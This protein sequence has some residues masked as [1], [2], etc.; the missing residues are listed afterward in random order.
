MPTFNNYLTTVSGSEKASVLSGLRALLGLPNYA[1]RYMSAATRVHPPINLNT[2]TSANN[3]RATRI[4][5]NTPDYPTYNTRLVY[6]NWYNDS[7]TTPSVETDTDGVLTL[8]AVGYEVGGVVTPVTFGGATTVDIPIGG[9]V[10][11]DPINR[12]NS[13]ETR[14]FVRT[15]DSVIAGNKRP[16]GWVAQVKNGEGVV[17]A[18]TKQTALATSGTISGTAGLWGPAAIIAQGWD[19]RDVAGIL[20]DSVT[21]GQN[22]NGNSCDL[23]GN[24]GFWARGLDNPVNGR[25]PYMMMARPASRAS[26]QAADSTGAM[27]RLLEMLRGIAALNTGNAWPFT[28]ITSGM[29]INDSNTSISTMTTDMQNWW[30]FLAATFS[31]LKLVQS[32]YGPRSSAAN[33]TLFTNLTDQTPTSPNNSLTTGP[34]MGLNA[35]IRSVPS[36]LT[37]FADSGPL[38]GD[39]TEP[40]KWA[41]RPFATT[42]AAAAASGATT[43]STVDRPAVEETL[44]FEPGDATNN[45]GALN[46][47]VVNVTGVGPFTV[48]LSVGLAKAHASG[49]IVR[50]TSVQDTLHPSSAAHKTSSAGIVA[51]K[52][53]GYIRGT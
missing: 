4:G 7:N 52:A 37:G 10:I 48:T 3:N 20:G 8:D 31:G 18:S 34:R 5:Y 26:Q 50:A 23:R 32:T 42:L 46:Y 29:G 11:S 27:K 24:A 13:P 12:M 36:P 44:C 21:F 16:S 40:L 1:D 17:L 47:A 43:I 9:F 53:A 2:T 25:V 45:D 14:A 49:A 41:V 6:V 35:L 51:A 15:A 33:N 38:F 30:N 19:G 28:V 22:D 39:T